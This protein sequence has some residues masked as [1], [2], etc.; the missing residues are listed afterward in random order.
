MRRKRKEN[1]QQL[2]LHSLLWFLVFLFLSIG[3]ANH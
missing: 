1:L 2:L 3:L